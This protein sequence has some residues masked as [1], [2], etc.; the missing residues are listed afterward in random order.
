[1]DDDSA[2]EM[3]SHHPL[4]S[5]HSAHHSDALLNETKKRI[6]NHHQV[7]QDDVLLI[8]ALEI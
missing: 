3:E 4:S 8:F 6:G 7:R 1:M 2:T 5:L